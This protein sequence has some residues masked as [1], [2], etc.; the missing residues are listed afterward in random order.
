M[1]IV[2]I[3]SLICFFAAVFFGAVQLFN[4]MRNSTDD[5]TLFSLWQRVAGGNGDGIRSLLPNGVAQ[6]VFTAIL[7][8]PAWLALLCLGGGLWM[9]DRAIN[10]ED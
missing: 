2:R 10:D 1:R 8:T 6:D 7:A 3:L 5:L 4:H 9:L